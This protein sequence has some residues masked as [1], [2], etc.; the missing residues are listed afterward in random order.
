VQGVRKAHY[1]VFGLDYPYWYGV[2]QLKQESG[3]RDILSKDG[4][5]SQGLAQIT[6]RW[7]KPFL[8]S[9]GI[10]NIGSVD[11][12]LLSQAYIMQDAKKQAYSKNLWVAYQVYNGGGLVNK[13]ISRA[14]LD[15]DIIE[16]SHSIAY[17]YCKRKIITFNS[18]QK[19]DACLINYEYSQKIYE[20]S[21]QYKMGQDGSYTFW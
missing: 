21:K 18:G 2:A 17:K 15:L 5:G 19:I 13:E 8:N 14:R 16:V 4:I 10:A 7:W 1:K 6:Y 3:C 12:Q 20:Y 11:N 9:K